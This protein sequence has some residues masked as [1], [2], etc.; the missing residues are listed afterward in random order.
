[1]LP[2]LK[3]AIYVALL[4][5]AFV[6][7]VYYDYRVLNKDDLY[8]YIKKAK[9][10]RYPLLLLYDGA[11][12][13]IRHVI[14]CDKGVKSLLQTDAG[15][16]LYC[17]D[18]SFAPLSGHG[19][20]LA[21]ADKHRAVTTPIDIVYAI[22]DLKSRGVSEHELAAFLYDV[23][24]C[25]DY[26]S[27]KKKTIEKFNKLIEE[28]KQD[29]KLMDAL[30]KKA[31]AIAK[32]KGISEELVLNELVKSEARAR[33]EAPYS[34]SLF[35]HVKPELVKYVRTGIN[36]LTICQ[37][38]ELARRA[39]ELEKKKAFGFDPMWL[40]YAAI[41]VLIIFIALGMRH[42]NVIHLA[43]SVMPSTTIHKPVVIHPKPAGHVTHATAKQ[44]TQTTKSTS[45]QTIK[46]Q[47]KK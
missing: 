43:H 5:I 8:L 37:E 4:G 13:H 7:G 16:W 35:M 39:G 21:I 18:G 23:A 19:V 44:T 40:I 3:Y 34:V 11:M 22:E 20:I 29:N 45:Q 1:M 46:P 47:L 28:V 30:K 14:N 32:E 10:K 15:E 33:M 42:T 26:E 12:Y 36:R 41:A 24:H 6:V 9:N 31:K 2:L 27:F 17:P 38:I 25:K